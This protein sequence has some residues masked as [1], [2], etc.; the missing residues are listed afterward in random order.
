MARVLGFRRGGADPEAGDVEAIFVDEEAGQAFAEGL[1][2]AIEGIRP[3]GGAAVE[4][5]VTGIE[6]R[7]MVGAGIDDRPGP[8]AARRLE[9]IVG[10]RDIGGV[11]LLEIILIGDA[12]E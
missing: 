10:A 7:R 3:M 9:D 8:M 4:A 1:A 6:T 12:A 5:L 2:D 11:D